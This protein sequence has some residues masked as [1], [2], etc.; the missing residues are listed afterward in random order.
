MKKLN[1]CLLV[2]FIIGALYGVYS[3]VYW[4][5]A[6]G[7][8]G[9]EAIGGAIALTLV[10]PH[11]VCTLIAIVFNGLGLFLRKQWFALVGAILYTVAMIVFPMYFMFI[12]IEMILSYIGFA[13]LHKQAKANVN[14]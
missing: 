14:G 3:L 10:M 6:M 13:Q 9:G 11:L 7:G 5:G 12:I 8:E 1:K 4:G 2:S